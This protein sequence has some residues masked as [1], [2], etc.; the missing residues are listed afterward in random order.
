LQGR[1]LGRVTAQG[2]SIFRSLV[3]GRRYSKLEI[4]DTSN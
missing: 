4:V 1:W 3:M 2:G